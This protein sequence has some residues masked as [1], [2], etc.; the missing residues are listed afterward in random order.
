MHDLKPKHQSDSASNENNAELLKQANIARIIGLM[1]ETDKT[2]DWLIEKIREKHILRRIDPGIGTYKI[3][4][5]CS[6][7]FTSELLVILKAGEFIDFSKIS[8][9]T[10]T[11]HWFYT[12]IVASSKDE[13]TTKD[14]ARKIIVLNS[15]IA[16]TKTFQHRDSQCKILPTGDGAV[17]GFT[18]SPESPLTLATELH[19]LLQRYNESKKGDE[20]IGI[21]IGLESGPVYLF[22]D[23]NQNENVWGPGIIMARRAMDLGESM[24]IIATDNYANS[25]RNLKEEYRRF[26]V[27]LAYFD[28]KHK[29]ILIYNVVGEGFGNKKIPDDRSQPTGSS[30]DSAGK[31][32]IKFVYEGIKVELGIANRK[33]WM[34]HHA[35][36]W[37]FINISKDPMDKLFY[38]IYGDVPRDFRNLNLKV[39][40][41][42][43]KKQ[44][45][46]TLDVNEPKQKEF[47]FKLTKPV[48]PGKKGFAKIEWDW[49]E[50]RRYFYYTFASRCRSFR[51]SA[52]IPRRVD[53]AQRVYRVSHGVKEKTHTTPATIKYT[54]NKVKVL[55]SAE[56]IPAYDAYEFHW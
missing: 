6:V 18:D 24:H 56:N 20:K 9:A 4:N 53:V 22:N 11:Y 29:E 51:F 39:T 31:I 7:E 33:T 41:S 3:L 12:D 45:L 5:A 2:E 46:I 14:Q 30:E 38:P 36:T 26:F 50:P 34:T 49:E 43:G 47:H 1:Q 28:T 19:K 37:N 17:I 27:E 13:V 10:R 23:L 35:I 48:P 42:H 16:M 15:L 52:D 21:K 54:R 44:E 32:P 55:W 25:V 40:D 8:P